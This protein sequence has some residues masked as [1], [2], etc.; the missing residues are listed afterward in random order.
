MVT[1]LQESGQRVSPFLGRD[2]GEGVR[3]ERSHFGAQG[4]AEFT[5]KGGAL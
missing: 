4:T 1:I 2:G 3:W 5:W